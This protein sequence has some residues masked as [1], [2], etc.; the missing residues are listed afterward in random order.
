MFDV[1]VYISVIAAA[2][3]IIPAIIIMFCYVVIIYIIW[4]KSNAIGAST[5]RRIRRRTTF[6]RF[7]FKE[8]S[9]TIDG[10][11]D[12]AVGGLTGGGG[13]SD[14]AGGTR[15]GLTAGVITEAVSSSRGV[16]PA[17]KI[18]T[19]KMTFIIVLGS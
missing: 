2:L 19:I 17:A 15:D 10:V 18:R 16:I 9:S 1:Q 5:R 7:L 11:G 6:C 13:S 12:G 4:K 3:F 8:R 14:D